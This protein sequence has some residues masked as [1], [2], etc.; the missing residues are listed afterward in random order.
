MNKKA[1]VLNRLLWGLFL[2]TWQI[3][4]SLYSVQSLNLT[5]V[6]MTSKTRNRLP[7][8]DDLCQSRYYLVCSDCELMYMANMFKINWNLIFITI[9]IRFKWYNN[10]IICY[11]SIRED[12]ELGKC[13][14]VRRV[15]LIPDQIL[16]L[17][18]IRQRC[19]MWLVHWSLLTQVYSLVNSLSIIP[20]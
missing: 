5:F 8:S 18:L 12:S 2:A 17:C 14:N 19:F 6:Q 3:P 16:C 4:A 1:A 7:W 10:V 13:K 15:D 11:D 20:I 9:L